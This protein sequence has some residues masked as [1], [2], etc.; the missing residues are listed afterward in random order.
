MNKKEDCDHD[1]AG[2][3]DSEHVLSSLRRRLIG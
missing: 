1:E 3:V 2:F